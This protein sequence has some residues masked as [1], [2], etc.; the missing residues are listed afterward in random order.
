M[1]KEKFITV[2]A[3]LDDD[4][5]RL[6]TRLQDDM[7][8]QY[9]ED[10]KTKGIPFHITLGSYP[11]E[12]TDEIVARIEAVAGKSSSVDIRLLGLNHFGN[13]VR[14]VEPEI[15]EELAALHSH[16]DSDYANGFDGWMPHITVYRHNEPKE[17][18]LT[19]AILH[20]VENLTSATITGI[21]LSE[22]FP[23][24]KIV[25]VSFREERE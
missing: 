7:E 19:E 6:L 24:E 23:P 14:F 16:F 11:V 12:S 22:F 25:W 10:T 5:Q 1:Q 9:G 8:R 21:E 13:V 4:T 17:I 2:M 18:Q 3:V 15:N 20:Q